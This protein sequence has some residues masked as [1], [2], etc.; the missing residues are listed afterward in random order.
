[1]KDAEQ[2][3]M[4]AEVGS[5]V[6]DILEK[7]EFKALPKS[8]RDLILRNPA[9]LSDADNV[10]EALLDIEDF[11]REQVAGLTVQNQPGQ[12]TGKSEPTG[13]QTPSVVNQGAPAPTGPGNL[14]NIDGLRGTALS[15]AILRNKMRQMK[16]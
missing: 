12:G 4:R 5:K 10:E 13:H 9:M 7:E 1:M 15:R 6:R 14:E 2:R 16:S 8:T 3:A 11:V